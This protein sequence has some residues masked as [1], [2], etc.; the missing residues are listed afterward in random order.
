MCACVCACVRACVLACVRACVCVCVRKHARGFLCVHLCVRVRR[1][2]REFVRAHA[3]VCV[4][5]CS[6]ARDCV[7]CVCVRVR[8]CSVTLPP[9]QPHSP[10]PPVLHP[11]HPL[12]PISLNL[13]TSFNSTENNNNVNS[14]LTATEHYTRFIRLKVNRQ[15][16]Y[17]NFDHFREPYNQSTANNLHHAPQWFRVASL[18]R[19]C[20]NNSFFYIFFIMIAS[21]K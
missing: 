6:H 1:V 4:Y 16:R 7:C 15:R 12:T 5:E 9:P 3:C 18:V 17:A 14:V 11:T 13:K 2:C 8:M 10:H 21:G 19:D 20:K